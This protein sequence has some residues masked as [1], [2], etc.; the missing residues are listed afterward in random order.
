MMTEL[1]VRITDN[2]N[3]VIKNLEDDTEILLM[4]RHCGGD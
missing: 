4:F 1:D 3:K 2:S